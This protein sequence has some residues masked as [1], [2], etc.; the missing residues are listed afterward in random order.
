VSPAPSD[1][2]T[3]EHAFGGQLSSFLETVIMPS[4]AIGEMLGE[5]RSLA[6]AIA[7]APTTAEAARIKSS[8]QLC[9]IVTSEGY[10]ALG[11]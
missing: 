6:K 4:F 3:I 2:K 5:I 1:F 9:V 10:A 7:D 8:F 11:V